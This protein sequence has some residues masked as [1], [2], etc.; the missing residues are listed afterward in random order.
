M[1]TQLEKLLSKQLTISNSFFF[2]QSKC[3]ALSPKF[4]CPCFLVS[5]NANTNLT[6]A[7][8]ILPLRPGIRTTRVYN[9]LSYF[10]AV[11]EALPFSLGQMLPSNVKFKECLL[12]APAGHKTTGTGK[13]L[14]RISLCHHP[15]TPFKTTGSRHKSQD[16]FRFVGSLTMRIMQEFNS[17]ILS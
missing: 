14:H 1:W 2:C 9:S 5:W 3:C 16:S 6:T 7:L 12:I 4:Y 13:S 11:P 17:S 10:P 15:R 8:V